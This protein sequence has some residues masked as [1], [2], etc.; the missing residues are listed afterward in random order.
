[1]IGVLIIPTGVG[2]ALGGHAGDANPLVK[3]IA[4]C[5]DKLIVHPNVVNA[6]DI[7]EMTDNTLY[8]EGSI[9]DIFLEGKISLKEIKQNKILIVANPP[10]TNTTINAVSTGRVTFGIKAEILELTSPLIMKGKIQNGIATG[11]V[12]GIDELILQLKEYN[13][14]ALAIHT[15]I[16][17]SRNVSLNYFRNGGINPWGGIEAKVSKIIAS[18]LC[19]PVAHAPLENILPED[20]ELYF[21]NEIVDPRIAPEVISNSYLQC[22]LKGLNKAPQISKNNKY[23]ICDEIDFMITP[24]M[25]YG[26]P[27]KACEKAN[28]PVIVVK[29]N[30]TILDNKM[31]SNFIFVENYWEAIGVIMSMKSGICPLSVR[32]PILK[33]KYR[34]ITN[35]NETI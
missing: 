19:K 11:D 9:L 7:N 23:L 6:S 4:S 31:P 34:R 22:V 17:V 27:H 35:E 29:E 13:F 21:F 32:R 18:K 15:P 24:D 5:C 28:I 3:L 25:C 12:N 30:T 33:T 16:E 8:V 20:V 14:D 10:L 26:R 2:A 1:M